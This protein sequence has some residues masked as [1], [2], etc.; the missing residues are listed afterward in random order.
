MFVAAKM[1]LVAAPANDRK[2]SISAHE[3]RHN[4]KENEAQNAR[5]A[6]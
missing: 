3:V 4:L 5:A 2:L 1:V 6:N